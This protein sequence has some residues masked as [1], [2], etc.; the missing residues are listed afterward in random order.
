M[1]LVLTG[2]TPLLGCIGARWCHVAAAADVAAHVPHRLHA[3]AGTA[4][5]HYAAVDVLAHHRHARAMPP[6]SRCST[7]P[8][9]LS[10]AVG[11]CIHHRRMSLRMDIDGKMLGGCVYTKCSSLSTST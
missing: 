10:Y 8:L 6:F 3:A 11:M 1:L 5:L 9:M 7:L 4:E 2:V